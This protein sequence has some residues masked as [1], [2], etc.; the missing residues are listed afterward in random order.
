MD[1]CRFHTSAVRPSSILAFPIRGR[2]RTFAKH[3]VSPF[4]LTCHSERLVLK[5][6]PHCPSYIALHGADAKP[7]SLYAIIINAQKFTA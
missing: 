1:Q 7:V 6:C 5:R 4:P 3:Q 2:C